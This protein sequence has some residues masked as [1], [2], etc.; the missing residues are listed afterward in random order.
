MPKWAEDDPAYH[1]YLMTEAPLICSGAKRGGPTPLLK[2]LEKWH[3]IIYYPVANDSATAG[4]VRQVTHNRPRLNVPVFIGRHGGTPAQFTP[5]FLDR[6]CRDLKIRIE[7]LESLW[8]GLDDADQLARAVELASWAHGEM[9]RIHPFC[10]GN[11]RM[12]RVL[13]N[14]ILHRFGIDFRLDL[15]PRPGGDYEACA[16]RSMTGDH[17]ATEGYLMR[18]IVM[19]TQGSN[20]S[21]APES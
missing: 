16:T 8:D 21:R 5:L 1:Q 18:V 6:M 13:T 2:D 17:A 20:D 10:N 4:H 9:V 12:A 15:K 14:W 3:K 11:G 7:A 19:S